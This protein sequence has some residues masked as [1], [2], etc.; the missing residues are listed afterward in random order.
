MKVWIIFR[1]IFITSS[2]GVN[3]VDSFGML[4]YLTEDIFN[5][6]HYEGMHDH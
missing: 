3:G 1:L 5:R 2:K 6:D 4:E